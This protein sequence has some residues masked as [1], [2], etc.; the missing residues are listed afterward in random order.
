MVASLAPLYISEV[1]FRSTSLLRSQQDMEKLPEQ[2]KTFGVPLDKISKA[3][4][5]SEATDPSKLRYAHGDDRQDRRKTRALFPRFSSGTLPG[6]G[7]CLESAGIGGV[8]GAPRLSGRDLG[9]TAGGRGPLR[10]A[11]SLFLSD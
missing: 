3:A 5:Q 2:T 7:H 1:S 9:Q 6:N 11:A 8:S 10:P 4:R